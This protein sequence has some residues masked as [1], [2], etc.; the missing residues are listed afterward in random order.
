MSGE[1]RPDSGMCLCL[2]D[3]Q[4]EEAARS[5]TR[6]HDVVSASGFDR[7]GKVLRDKQSLT[8]NQD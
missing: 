5:M 2:T 8:F 6:K 3:E 7:G 1:N 4:K